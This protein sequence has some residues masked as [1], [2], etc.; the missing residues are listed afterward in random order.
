[1][2]RLQVVEANRVSDNTNL[3]EMLESLEQE[4]QSEVLQAEE[5]SIPLQAPAQSAAVND[6]AVSENRRCA[7]E[8]FTEACR[9]SDQSIDVG[10]MDAKMIHPEFKLFAANYDQAY[11]NIDQRIR[12]VGRQYKRVRERVDEKHRETLHLRRQTLKNSISL[13]E[14]KAS[15]R[16]AGLQVALQQQVS[17]DNSAY[18]ESEVTDEQLW[19]LVRASKAK[20]EDVSFYLETRDSITSDAEN[21][22]RRLDAAMRQEQIRLSADRDRNLQAAEEMMRLQIGSIVQDPQYKFDSSKETASMM[23]HVYKNLRQ[24]VSQHD[25]SDGA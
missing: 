2:E 7:K 10:A 25:A 21:A 1:M 14:R 18:G 15:E 8:A 4:L 3:R 23:F 13:I 9:S 24:M 12:D 11:P 6:P 17:A 19:D 16:V 22:K 20:P 5:E